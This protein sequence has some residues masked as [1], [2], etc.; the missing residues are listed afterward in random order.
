MYTQFFGNFLLGQNIITPEQLIKL[1]GKESSSEITLGTRALY[2]NLLSAS[3][4]DDMIQVQA[5]ED[6]PLHVLAVE[7]NFL[8]EEQVQQL[9]DEQVPEYL[10]LGQLLMEEGIITSSDFEN[11]IIDY[12]TQHEIYD[13]DL[14]ID[15][16][17]QVTDLI[18]HYFKL[19]DVEKSEIYEEYLTLLFNNLIR[20]IGEDFT[21]MAPVRCDEYPVQFSIVQNISGKYNIMTAIDMDP[22]AAIE[23]SSRYASEDFDKFDEY[24]QSSL[25]DFLNL[26][27]GLFTVNMSNIHAVE[28]QLF[29]PEAHKDGLLN[30]KPETVSY[31]FPILY[32]FGTVNIVLSF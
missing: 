14:Q 29:P 4:V 25:E 30:F 21:P 27:N 12:E 8:T 23:F 13:L 20:F 22:P 32:P 9:L 10:L 31:M 16:K 1:I 2:R 6:K 24:I 5:Q 7:Q 28:L 11:L 17:E 26:H 15:Q 18:R 19:E 3:E